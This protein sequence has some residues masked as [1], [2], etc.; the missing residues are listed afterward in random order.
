MPK[1][2]EKEYQ[3]LV[4][5]WTRLGFPVGSQL[6]FRNERQEIVWGPDD[7][8]LIIEKYEKLVGPKPNPETVEG[9]SN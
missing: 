7:A 5:Q 4:E 3:Q 1:G 8:D 9:V 2:P 6:S